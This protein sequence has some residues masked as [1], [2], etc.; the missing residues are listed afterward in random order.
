ML[1]S[2]SSMLAA[3]AALVAV[4][5]AVLLA[6]RLARAGGFGPP[7]GSGRLIL[8]QETAALDARRR[9]HLVSCDGP[10][11]LRLTG[12]GTDVVVGWLDRPDT[13]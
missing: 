5:A 9:L 7:R 10:P 6:G 8:V 3:F 13:P 4:L 2:W 1:P 11:Q 12:G